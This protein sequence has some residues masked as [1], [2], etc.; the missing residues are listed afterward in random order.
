LPWTAPPKATSKRASKRS[1]LQFAQRVAAVFSV[2]ISFL[3]ARQLLL[4]L[5]E[6]APVRSDSPAFDLVAA[7]QCSGWA[8]PFSLLPRGS[9]EALLQQPAFA[10]VQAQCL[11]SRRL[12]QFVSSVQLSSSFSASEFESSRRSEIDLED[13]PKSPPVLASGS[14]RP[15]KHQCTQRRRSGCGQAWQNVRSVSGTS[16][17]GFAMKCWGAR[18]PRLPFLAPPREKLSQSVP[19]GT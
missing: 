4:A 17:Y 1:P 10:R 13:L 15:S 11:A 16:T 12:R 3:A 19:R 8:P 6:E 7:R 5:P 14:H 2:E 9:A 18:A